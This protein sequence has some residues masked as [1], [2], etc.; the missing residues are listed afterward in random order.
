[1]A[2]ALLARQSGGAKGLWARAAKAGVLVGVARQMGG[3]F[4]EMANDPS[5]LNELTELE[6][7]VGGLWDALEGL[8]QGLDEEQMDGVGF[9]LYLDMHLRISKSLEP[10][11]SVGGAQEV[12][13]D[14]W[15]TDVGRK[16]LGDNALE[17]LIRQARSASLG[18]ENL[19]DE[20]LNKH[21]FVAAIFE[22]AAAWADRDSMACF[23]RALVGNLGSTTSVSAEWQ[24]WPLDT[25]Q[26]L[27]ESVMHGQ[28]LDQHRNDSRQLAALGL[29]T[30][31]R[32]GVL[33]SLLASDSSQNQATPQVAVEQ[34]C[35]PAVLHSEELPEPALVPEQTIMPQHEIQPVASADV[36]QLSQRHTHVVDLKAVPQVQSRTSAPMATNPAE[37]QLYPVPPV[38]S[39]T[40]GPMDTNTRQLQPQLE[41][42]VLGASGGVTWHESVSEGSVDTQQSAKPQQGPGGQRPAFERNPALAPQLDPAPAPAPAPAPEPEPEPEVNLSRADREALGRR[43]TSTL[44]SLSID[45]VNNYNDNYSHGQPNRAGAASPLTLRMRARVPRK[46]R[47]RAAK[48]DSQ[49][50]RFNR[51]G[52]VAGSSVARRPPDGAAV[53]QEPLHSGRRKVGGFGLPKSPM[54]EGLGDSNSAA[55]LSSIVTTSSRQ[56]TLED[57]LH[58]VSNTWLA[59]EDESEAGSSDE[60]EHNDWQGRRHEPEVLSVTLEP[61]STRLEEQAMASMAAAKHDHETYQQKLALEHQIKDRSAVAPLQHDVTNLDA[62]TTKQRP[63]SA[64]PSSSATRFAKHRQRP[65]SA[66]VAREESDTTCFVDGSVSALDVPRRRRRRRKPPM[67]AFKERP[68]RLVCRPAPAPQRLVPG[69]AELIGGGWSYVQPFDTRHP[70]YFW[71][72]RWKRGVWGHPMEPEPQDRARMSALVAQAQ[73]GGFPQEALRLERVA[74]LAEFR[75]GAC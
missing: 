72:G 1:M 70:A 40:S 58:R 48:R 3:E 15:R 42:E 8:Q 18:K 7:A 31:A 44:A 52:V 22:L 43:A 36:E 26:L 55:T 12:C 37:P 32:Q 53:G 64:P 23:T 14:D 29:D 21:Q 11:F 68:T 59:S 51:L 47:R 10:D 45:D 41:S 38:Q 4:A 63:R 46:H 61:L 13:L 60:D 65:S 30:A 75:A 50:Q 9:K 17:Q 33:S 67:P 69:R 62:R 39:W 19:R 25:V 28:E 2:A 56:S 34:I 49:W 35:Q 73:D 71:H 6:A 24:F 54:Q 20:R 16:M 27:P 57:A 66:G 74:Q 5:M